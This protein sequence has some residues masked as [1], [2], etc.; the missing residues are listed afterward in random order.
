MARRLNLTLETWRP[1]WRASRVELGAKAQ[2]PSCAVASE[3]GPMD[4]ESGPPTS[5]PVCRS[6]S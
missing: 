6:M 3:T 5:A 1:I 2:A 4:I